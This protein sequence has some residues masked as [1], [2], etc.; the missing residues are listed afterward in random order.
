M[1]QSVYTLTP[2]SLKSD[3]ILSSH[4]YLCLPN[5]VF[6]VSFLTKILHAFFMYL[7]H[8]VCPSH[9]L[10]LS[11]CYLVKS[12][13][14]EA[15]HNEMFSVLVLVS[16]ACIQIFSLARCFDTLFHAYT[17]EIK[18]LNILIMMF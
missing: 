13:N 15:S 5:S 17:G 1:M 10:F 4:L 2:V 18:V 6:S 3:L 7:I 16:P 9:P 8:A 12:T 14:Y 11:A